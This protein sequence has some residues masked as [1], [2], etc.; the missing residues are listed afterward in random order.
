[1]ISHYNRF[2]K[3]KDGKIVIWQKPNLPLYAWALFK[4]MAVLNTDLQYKVAFEQISSAFLF[5][6]GFLELTQ[7]V[8]KFRRLLGFIVMMIVIVGYIKN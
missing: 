4:L 2:F 3:D 8:S 1:M 6:W 5:T 7:G